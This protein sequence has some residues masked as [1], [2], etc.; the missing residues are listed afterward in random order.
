MIDTVVL[1]L[2]Y[3]NY[4][5][6]DHNK[7]IPSTERLFKNLKTGFGAKLYEKYIQNPPKSGPYGPRLTITARK[8]D[9]RLLIPLRMEFSIPK[10]LYGDNV[11]EVCEADLNK[12]V[13]RLRK[14]LKDM[15]VWVLTKDLEEAT[16]SI[17]H[18]AKNILLSGGYTCHLTINELKKLDV[19]GKLQIGQ[20]DYNNGGHLLRF[21]CGT[22]EIVFY[23]K[24]YDMGLPETAAFD[25]EQTPGQLRLLEE[26]GPRKPEILRLEARF[27][28][29]QKLNAVLKELGF[30]ENPRFKEIFNEKL[31][32]AVLRHYWSFIGTEKYAFMLKFQE[33][34]PDRIIEAILQSGRRSTKE[35]LALLGTALF[36]R[37]HGIRAFKKVVTDRYSSRTWLR[38]MKKE[39]A[40]LNKIFKKSTPFGFVKDVEST[41][42]EFKPFKTV[43]FQERMLNNDKDD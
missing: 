32:Q 39:I 24:S 42:R 16:V 40:E 43:D 17:V 25:K 38:R 3:G 5:V 12:V 31:S 33:E 27:V 36:L 8:V 15:G 23:D 2:D 28:K 1:I 10:L 13:A 35:S 34:K 29:K 6:T 14:R 19:S 30:K 22:Y 11:N 4:R 26:W 41:L 37:E 9:K 7:F 18:F 21:R 20:T